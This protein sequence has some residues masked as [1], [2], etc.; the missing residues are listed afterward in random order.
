MKDPENGDVHK[1]DERKPEKYWGPSDMGINVPQGIDGEQP[2][3]LDEIMSQ[4]VENI[5]PLKVGS[6]LDIGK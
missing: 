5:V 3:D 2:A 4:E 1:N 6:S